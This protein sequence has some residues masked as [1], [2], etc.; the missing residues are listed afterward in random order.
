MA[1][2]PGGS[3]VTGCSAVCDG[4][5]C[6]KIEQVSSVALLSLRSTPRVS[7]RL[8]SVRLLPKF[9]VKIR[10]EKCFFALVCLSFRVLIFSHL[11]LSTSGI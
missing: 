5:R 8:F 11:M 2:S 9:E 6:V 7:L 4:V 10:A 1:I 3:L